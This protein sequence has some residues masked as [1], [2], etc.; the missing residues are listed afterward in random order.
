MGLAE[1]IVQERYRRYREQTEPPLEPPAPMPDS[2]R[3][4]NHSFDCAF[5]LFQRECDCK[6][7]ST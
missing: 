7:Q 1:R 5:T 2:P 4:P 6:Q 3:K